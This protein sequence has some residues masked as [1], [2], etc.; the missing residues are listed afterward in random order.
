MKK[1]RK[2]SK[3]IRAVLRGLTFLFPENY[4]LVT[5][6]IRVVSDRLPKEFDG[7][8]ILQISDLHGCSFGRGNRRLLAAVERSRPDLIAMTGDM[9]D[10]RIRDLGPTAALVHTLC[11][12]YPVYFVEG[13]HEQT[14]GGERRDWFEGEMRA[15][16][17]RILRNASAELRRGSASIRLCGVR[18]PLRYY[19]AGVGAKPRPVLT[20][21]EMEQFVGKK[22][23][24][25][26][27]LLAH[28]PLCFA[29]YAAWGAD[30][31][32]CGHVHGGMV[33]LPGGRGLLSP[34]RTF[35]PP[36][37]AGAYFLNGCEMV[38][39]RGLAAG[40]RIG[41]VPELVE[42][43]LCAGTGGGKA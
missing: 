26:T 21:E 6:H 15:A 10:R 8:R 18:V 14:L 43:T 19:R 34:E 2:I 11:G 12:R 5:T 35:F 13:N 17:A 16:G 37:S 23:E 32:L 41:N 25:Y 24:E 39:S 38:V 30:L 33:R 40:P 29:A 42:V 7:F 9:A 20:G 27:V 22:P 31:T 3:L 36:Y 28:N 4:F 1:K